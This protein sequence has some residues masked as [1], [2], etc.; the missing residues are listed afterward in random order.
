MDI[1]DPQFIGFLP[2]LFLAAAAFFAGL[3]DS[4][5]GGGGLISLPAT[6]VVGIPPH[7]ALGTGKFMSS[8]GTTA[9]FITYARN[10]AIVWRIVAVGIGFSFLGSAVGAETALYLDNAVLGKIILFLL[11]VAAALTFVPV[12]GRKNMAEPG[13]FVLYCVTP[14]TCSLIG[15]YDGFFGPGTGS[16]M[17]LALHFFLGLHLIAAS[18]TAKAFNLAS[19][20][21]GLVVFFINGKIYY[22]A[23]IPMAIANVAGNIVGSRLALRRGPTLVRKMLLISL[24]LLF[25]TLIWRYYIA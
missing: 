25:V 1:A 21:S 14:L 7:L 4:V 13:K 18:G 10:G 17:L 23:A 15:F 2:I 16:F 19:N 22:Y 11:P 3:L 24:A 5:A 20:I 6:L 8:I 12:R 9:A